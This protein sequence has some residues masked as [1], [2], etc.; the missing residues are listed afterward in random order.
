MTQTKIT[1][2][3]ILLP[4]TEKAFA[5]TPWLDINSAWFTMSSEEQDRWMDKLDE[6]EAQKRADRVS[7]LDV[8]TQAITKAASGEPCSLVELIAALEWS[9]MKLNGARKDQ[10][11]LNENSPNGLDEKAFA[12]WQKLCNQE[13]DAAY[14]QANI[15]RAIRAQYPDMV[16]SVIAHY[17]V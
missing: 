2:E 6:Y 14:N 17:N 16:D 1:L 13:E 8:R 11:L 4:N 3:D 15:C 9:L 7:V 5:R 12:Y 10:T